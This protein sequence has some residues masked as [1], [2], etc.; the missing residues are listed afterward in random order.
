MKTISIDTILLREKI[1]LLKIEKEKIDKALGV[2]YNDSKEIENIWSGNFADI[3]RDD[4]VNYSNTFEK[5][6]Y[7]LEKYIYFLEGVVELHEKKDKTLNSVI[8]KSFEK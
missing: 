7:Q 5:I 4:L 2:V 3:V 6:S 8:D 1:K